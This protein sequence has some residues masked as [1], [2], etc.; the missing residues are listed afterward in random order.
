MIP[1][2]LWF[3]NY[4]LFQF[5]YTISAKRFRLGALITFIANVIHDTKHNHII[6]IDKRSNSV[7]SEYLIF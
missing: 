7:A 6:Y 3:L 4:L 5:Y 2:T 1:I